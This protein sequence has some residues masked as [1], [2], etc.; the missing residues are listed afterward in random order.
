MGSVVLSTTPTCGADNRHPQ[1]LHRSQADDA[2]AL[3]PPF[4][5]VPV[6]KAL[7]ELNRLKEEIM[8]NVEAM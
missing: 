3:W 5:G 4:Q 1:A 8:P 6:A 2:A 7:D